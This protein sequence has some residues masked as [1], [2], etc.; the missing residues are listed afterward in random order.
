MAMFNINVTLCH[1]NV[2][3]A[4][5][6][7]TACTHSHLHAGLTIDEVRQHG[8]AAQE[9]AAR[10]AELQWS[11]QQQGDNPDIDAS[12]YYHV[13]LLFHPL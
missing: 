4:P 13:D 8:K 6:K 3:T 11:A 9:S 5:C 2:D 7:Y 1:C 10:I 12:T